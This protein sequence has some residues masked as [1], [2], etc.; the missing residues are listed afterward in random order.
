MRPLGAAVLPLEGVVVEIA[1]E[2]DA[3][4]EG[5]VAEGGQGA[6]FGNF[7]HV[8]DDEDVAFGGGV[9][10]AQGSEDLG[11]EGVPGEALVLPRVP[12]RETDVGEVDD[13][14]DDFRVEGGE[15]VK[16][17]LEV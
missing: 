5:A 6:R 12:G 17:G 16:G 4:G 7:V 2:G 15:A 8:P 11:E 14:V 3:R 13:S 1:H 10:G 9:G